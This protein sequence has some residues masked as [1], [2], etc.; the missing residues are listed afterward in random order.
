IGK[1]KFNLYTNMCENYV[2]EGYKHLYSFEKADLPEYTFKINDTK[3]VK[4]ISMIY[5][6]N[7]VVVQYKIQ[8]GKL[9]ANLT[10]APIINFRDFHAMTPN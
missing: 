3:I 7:T 1:E 5:G 9:P 10:L 6:R 8:N 4:K 2:S